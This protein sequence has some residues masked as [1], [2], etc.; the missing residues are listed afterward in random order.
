MLFLIYYNILRAIQMIGIPFWI[1]FQNITIKFLLIAALYSP[2]WRAD[3]L[4]QILMNYIIKN[5]KLHS[6]IKYFVGHERRSHC[7]KFK[8]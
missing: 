7:P 8:F 4:L 6:L 1:E 3:R 5:S 2:Y